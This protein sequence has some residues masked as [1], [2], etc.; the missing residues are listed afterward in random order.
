MYIKYIMSVFLM[1]LDY[2]GKMPAFVH[3]A[4]DTEQLNL[5]YMMI[6]RPCH[7]KQTSCTW[8]HYAKS[9]QQCL[10]SQKQLVDRAAYFICSLQCEKQIVLCQTDWLILHI[11]FIPPFTILV[12]RKSNQFRFHGETR[13]TLREL[14]SHIIF[15]C[16]H[17]G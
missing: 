8:W 16:I 3:H 5:F 10:L 14:C 7:E 12:L 15:F 4:C 13:H 17:F 2:L 9:P 1:Q 11:R 6:G